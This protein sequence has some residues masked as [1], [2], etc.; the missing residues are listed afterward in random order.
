MLKIIIAVSLLILTSCAGRAPN[1]VP[2]TEA[3]NST[4]TCEAIHAEIAANTSQIAKLGSEQGAKA[5]QNVA[6][7]IAGLIIWPLWFAMDFQGAAT[8]E[9]DALEARN[10]YLGQRALQ[11]CTVVAQ[12]DEIVPPASSVAYLRAVQEPRLIVQSSQAPAR[13]P[14]TVRAL[15]T[16]APPP[17]ITVEARARATASPVE[18]PQGDPCA[19]YANTPTES[20]CRLYA[21]SDGWQSIPVAGRHADLDTQLRCA[22]V[23]SS[24]TLYE[25]CIS[26]TR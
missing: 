1:P 22:P 5:A 25:Q 12:K 24:P 15:E 19:K 7:G 11:T 16:S 10:S 14:V 26:G 6:A 13:T 21:S 17:V 23:R 2:V 8:K 3:K 9:I 20:R 4:M 18:V